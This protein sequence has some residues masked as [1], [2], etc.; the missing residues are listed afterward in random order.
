MLV[1]ALAAL[2]VAHVTP[3]LEHVRRDALTVRT[4]ADELSARRGVDVAAI[5]DEVVRTLRDG[6]IRIRDV[7]SKDGESPY[8]ALA[9]EIDAFEQRDTPADSVIAF[10]IRVTI[11]QA[12]L[13]P[14]RTMS[15]ADIWSRS[16]VG[17]AAPAAFLET[18]RGG[19]DQLVIAVSEDLGAYHPDPDDPPKKSPPAHSEGI[20]L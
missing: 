1:A 5:R 15:K 14:D 13:L 3:E 7:G 20:V 10:T 2:A 12:V 17:I 18:V 9:I 16:L 19:L 4:E 8:A 6:G 11:R